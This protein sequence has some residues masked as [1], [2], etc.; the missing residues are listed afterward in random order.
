M[1]KPD[2]IRPLGS[3]KHIFWG[4]HAASSAGKTTFISTLPNTL[5]IRPPVEHTESVSNPARGV[6]EWVVSDWNEMMLNGGVLEYLQHEGH[7]HAFVWLDS[8]SGW[9]DVGLDDVWSDTVTRFPHRKKTPI[10]RG[11]YNANMVR[12]AQFVRACVGFDSFNFGFTAWPEPLED[13]ETGKTMLMPWI[14]GKNMSNRFVGYMKLVTYMERKETG[15][16]DARKMVRVMRWGENDN[17]FTKDQIHL[18]PVGRMVNPTMP[19][20]MKLIEEARA[21]RK[22]SASSRTKKPVRRKRTS[23]ASRRVS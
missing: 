3:S 10:D 7:K 19:Q 13:A 23:A 4:I 5:I 9:Q 20:M 2:Q 14:Q 15:P 18:P 17:Y 12:M 8:A 11:E 21:K 16:K 1:S 6:E 22:P